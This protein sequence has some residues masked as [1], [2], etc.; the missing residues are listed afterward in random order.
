MALDITSLPQP[1]LRDIRLNLGASKEDATLPAGEC[2][3]QDKKIGKMK[4]KRAFGCFLTW[5]GLGGWGDVLITAL[6]SL[7][8]AKIRKPIKILS[9]H[10]DDDFKPSINS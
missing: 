1:V 3:P 2:Q 7:R 8:D 9:N 5:N 10:G 4:P 6:D